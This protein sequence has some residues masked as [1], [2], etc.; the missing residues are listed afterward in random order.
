MRSPDAMGDLFSSGAQISA[1][2][3]SRLKGGGGE[4]GRHAYQ[5]QA[6]GGWR[7]DDLVCCIRRVPNQD[8][9]CRYL[10]TLYP[11]SLYQ[12]MGYLKQQDYRVRIHHNVL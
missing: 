9:A 5:A 6:G 2:F 12:R 7:T 8:L 10:Y 3:R 1:L 11:G 4:R